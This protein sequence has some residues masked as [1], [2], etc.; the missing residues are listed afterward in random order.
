VSNKKSMRRDQVVWAYAHRLINETVVSWASYAAD[1]VVHYERL[2]AVEVRNIHWSQHKDVPTRMKLDGQ[3]LRRFEGDYKSAYGLPAELEESMVMA[4][5]EPYKAAC[6]A[7]LAA[8]YGCYA[9]P[10]LEKGGAVIGLGTFA[11]EVGEWLQVTGQM[12]DDGVINGDDA[13]LAQQAI[14][15]GDDVIAA[16]LALQKQCEAV[17]PVAD[18]DSMKLRVVSNK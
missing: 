18:K 1:V 15:E 8:R 4:L 10:V 2:V 14:H 12:L 13:E 6:V 16:V 11:I 17:L 9:T 3:D 5:P 7:D